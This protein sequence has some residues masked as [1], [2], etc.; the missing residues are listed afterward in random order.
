MT[1]ESAVLKVIWELPWSK[2]L[3]VLLTRLFG[4]AEGLMLL[5]PSELFHGK[6]RM[7]SQQRYLQCDVVCPGAQDAQE[8]SDSCSSSDSRQEIRSFYF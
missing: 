4:V 6:P 8:M 5:V 1:L 2:P 7:K 3:S